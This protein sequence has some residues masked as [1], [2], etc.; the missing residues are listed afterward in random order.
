M[1]LTRGA[2]IDTARAVYQSAAADI[3]EHAAR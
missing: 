3:G 1:K 2:G